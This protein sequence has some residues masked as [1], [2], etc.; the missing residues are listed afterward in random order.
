MNDKS[1]NAR[2]GISGA[3]R[4]VAGLVVLALAVLGVLVVFDVIP[5][6]TLVNLSSKLVLCAAIFVAASVAIGMLSRR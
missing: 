3:T 1:D 4:L 6:E 2:T 5:R